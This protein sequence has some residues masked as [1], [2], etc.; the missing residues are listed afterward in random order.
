[1]FS[2]E[3]TT[4][5]DPGSVPVAIEEDETRPV[6]AGELEVA[7]RQSLEI[8]E[9]FDPTSI[10]ATRTSPN[11][12]PRPFVELLIAGA[13]TVITLPVHRVTSTGVVLTVPAGTPFDLA[14]DTP[15]TA[16]IHLML[17]DDE[18][19]RA[20]LPAHVAHHRSASANA[21]GGLSLRWD[22]T[23]PGARRAVESLLADRG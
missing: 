7:A 21:P 16:V 15:V 23:D 19:T 2:D 3:P 10:P 9:A 22:L 11:A 5:Y 4:P 17:S 12:R 20:R 18:V 8:T 1:V 6:D 14:T 13:G